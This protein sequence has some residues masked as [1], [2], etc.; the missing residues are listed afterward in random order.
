[1][2]GFARTVF[3][4]EFDET[5]VVTESRLSLDEWTAGAAEHVAG[6]GLTPRRLARADLPAANAAIEALGPHAEAPRPD[7]RRARRLY[8]TRRDAIARKR[9]A[10]TAGAL[11]AAGPRPSAWSRRS[12]AAT[13]QAVHLGDLAETL[14]PEPAAG[15]PRAARTSGS[16]S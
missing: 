15:P 9:S 6:L 3:G 10:A 14:F 13:E 7:A 5:S 12:P 1:M 11:L 16:R 4:D 8:D 2:I